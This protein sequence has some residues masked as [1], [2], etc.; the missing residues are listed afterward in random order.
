MEERMKYYEVAPEGL[1]KILSLEKYVQKN[2]EPMLLHLVKLRASQINGCAYCIDL[3]TKEATKDG[4]SVQR[5]HLLSAWH[6]SSLYSDKERAALA[7]TE[8]LTLISETGAR[9]EIYEDLENHFTDEE[10]VNLTY[11]IGTINMWNRLGVGFRMQHPV[12]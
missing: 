5:L 3:H 4:E 8:E 6:E 2:V 10:I 1:N 11:A 7:W 9:D 12:D